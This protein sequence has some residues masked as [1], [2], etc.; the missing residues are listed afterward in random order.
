MSSPRNARDIRRLAMQALYLLD[1]TQPLPAPTRRPEPAPPRL[2]RPPRTPP[3][4][5]TE[6]PTETNDATLSPVARDRSPAE[7]PPPP[8]PS[9]AD[10][11]AQLDDEYDKDEPTRLAAAELALAAWANR[12]T[13]D[14]A[15]TSLAP[16]WPANRQPPVDRAIL[17]LAHY[18]IT[19][20]RVADNIAINE[21]I[22]LAK[23]FADEPSPPFINGLLDKIAKIAKAQPSSTATETAPASADAWLHDAKSDPV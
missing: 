13:A 12:D 9:P 22:E 23:T 10:L 5:T 19:T 7:T 14:A 4:P 15:F 6:Q 8:T 2:P 11:A 21:A 3:E 18:E 1:V 16:D 20:G 17:R